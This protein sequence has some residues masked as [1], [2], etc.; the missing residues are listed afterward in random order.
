MTL[1]EVFKAEGIPDG[2]VTA[3]VIVAEGEF[4]GGRKTI[5]TLESVDWTKADDGCWY[6]E[7]LCFTPAIAKLGD[8][9]NAFEFVGRNGPATFL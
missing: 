3:T 8:L 6:A 7:G 5:R 4:P 2:G 9:Q 1:P